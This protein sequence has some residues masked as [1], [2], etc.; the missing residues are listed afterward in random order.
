MAGLVRGL[1][2]SKV[3]NLLFEGDVLRLMAMTL[4]VRPIG[5]VTQMLMA[6]YFGAGEQYDAYVLAFFLVNF[7]QMSFGRVFNA[8]VTPF[9]IRIRKER[10]ESDVFGFLNA[11]YLL[12]LI[13]GL[14]F[15]AV[16]LTRGDLLVFLSG[17][18]AP[19][20]TR[21]L[22][23][24]MLEFMAVPGLFFLLVWMG[25]S[26]LNLNKRFGVPGA[27]PIVY[28][29]AFLLVLVLLQP[30]RGIWALPTAFTVGVA[31]Q[32]VVLLVWNLRTG[33]FRFQ[34]PRMSATDRHKLW[35][36][37]WMIFVS[38]TFQTVN[39]FLDK[40]FASGLEPGSISSIAYSNTVINFGLQFFSLSLVTVMFTKMSELLSEE[41]MADCDR[42]IA[43]NL[44][45]MGRLV[46]PASIGLSLISTE[47]V[48]VLFERGQFGPDDTVR[49]AGA[50]SL[51]LL[52]LPALVFN[53]L[54][55]RIFHSI[56]KMRAK[57]WL[58]L[59][60]LLTNAVG[61]MILVG[62]FKVLG[63]AVSSSVAINVHLF[64][65][66][67]FLHR[68]GLGLGIERYTAIVLRLYTVGALV[69]GGFVASGAQAFFTRWADGA[70]L[71]EMI[72][73]GAVHFFCV[74]GAF[75]VLY[76]ISSRFMGKGPVRPEG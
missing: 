6:S 21:D 35:L 13:P 2:I 57:M 29:V 47:L 28:S 14:V 72:G 39:A 8:T 41:R 62:S 19:E 54:V 65:S 64:L 17:P 24:R 36:L 49:T 45:K 4:L 37:S 71:F 42:Y 23:L 25:K 51:Y 75:F 58:A 30:S 18:R 74:V 38:T 46:V 43:F 67:L 10:A 66:F 73:I 16:S 12:F 20:P 53:S 50:L 59:Q 34:R 70:G 1:Q 55:T 3:R 48:T 52:G 7:V 60:Y 33:S 11:A 32:F 61:N 15:V 26:T 5:L 68:Y 44:L 40:M 76:V 31:A 22:A 56:Q 27:M 9:A 69:W 63:L